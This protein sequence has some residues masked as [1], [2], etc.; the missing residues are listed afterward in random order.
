MNTKQMEEWSSDFGRAY[1]DRGPKTPEEVDKEYIEYFGI[2][3]S[4]LDKEFLD[5]LDRDMRILEVGCNVGSILQGL[6][7]MGFKKLYGI[8]L[9][10][11]AIKLSHKYC[12]GINIIQ[13][14]AFDIPFKDGFFDMTYTSGV[15]IHIAPTD[16]ERALR[17]I[18]R[19]SKRYIWGCE[20]FSETYTAVKKYRDEED[21]L[22]K[23]DFAKLYMK[24]FPDLNLLKERR[25]SYLNSDN[26]D[27]MF[28]LE[29]R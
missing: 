4:S 23:T 21:L 18:H 5:D 27:S 19:C 14:T 17:E 22:W 20:Y 25:F 28:L 9:Q 15:L 2:T 24:Y 8:E 12:D 1:T 6:Q 3:R 10:P 13:G 11:Y 29:K 7:K 16:I 26:V